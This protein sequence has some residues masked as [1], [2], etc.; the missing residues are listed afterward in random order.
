VTYL[1][2]KQGLLDQPGTV[3]FLVIFGMGV[4]L[5]FVFRS[6]ARHLRKINM[7]ARAEEEAAAKA[8][9]E[10]EGGDSEAADGFG[11]GAGGDAA[12]QSPTRTPGAD[13]GGA[14]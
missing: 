7:A 3:A 2:T 1:A 10:A 6:M 9:A 12:G 5:F 8:A 4:I 14:S 11:E 13:P